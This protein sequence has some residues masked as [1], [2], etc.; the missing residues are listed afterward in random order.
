MAF[1]ETQVV[2][3]LTG[4]LVTGEIFRLDLLMQ[5]IEHFLTNNNILLNV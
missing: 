4:N 1:G 2:Q 3:I 5:V